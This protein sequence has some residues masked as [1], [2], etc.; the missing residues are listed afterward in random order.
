MAKN[1]YLLAVLS[2]IGKDF[3]FLLHKMWLHNFLIIAL[4]MQL[5]NKTRMR[6]YNLKILFGMN[7]VFLNCIDLNLV[8][9]AK[10]SVRL[11]KNF[12]IFFDIFFF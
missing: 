2:K 8:T 6:S 11:Q 7:K 12:H 1:I 4:I 9:N 5:F 10:N 3:L